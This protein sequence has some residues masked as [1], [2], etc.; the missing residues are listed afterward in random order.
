MRVREKERK[1][2][3]TLVPLPNAIMHPPSSE[4]HCAQNCYHQRLQE[5]WKLPLINSPLLIP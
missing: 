4:F 3:K 5:N 2:E 1:A